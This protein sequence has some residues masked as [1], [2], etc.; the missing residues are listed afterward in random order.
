MEEGPLREAA[1]LTRAVENVFRKLVRLLIGRM[2]LTKLQEMIRIIFVEETEQKL[3]KERSGRNV[4][5]TKLALLTGLDTRTISKILEE[6]FAVQN[7]H[8]K[9]SPQ[10]HIMPEVAV[11]DYWSSNKRY[12]DSN[13]SKPLVLKLKGDYPSFDSLLKEAIPSRGITPSSILERFAYTNSVLYDKKS[14]RIKLL[15]NK[16]MSFVLPGGSAQFE[17][18]MITIGRLIDTLIHNDKPHESIENAFF[19]RSIWSEQVSEENIVGF[20]EATKNFLE[21]TEKEAVERMHPFE[22]KGISTQIR[23]GISM[24]YFEDNKIEKNIEN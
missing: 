3:K 2:S 1:I 15:N 20:R 11:L 5:L 19:Q 10:K 6:K 13:D 17:N 22:K 7:E 18:G 16:Y 9:G 4:P 8:K 21:T 14:K 24:F 12:L 23:A